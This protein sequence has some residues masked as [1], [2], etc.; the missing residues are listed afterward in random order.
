MAQILETIERLS[1]VSV[2]VEGKVD[3]LTNA[4]QNLAFAVHNRLDPNG[5]H[6]EAAAAKLEQISAT[7]SRIEET[8]KNLEPNQ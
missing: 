8:V 6:N 2:R 5:N 7:I 1:I 4:V 3:D